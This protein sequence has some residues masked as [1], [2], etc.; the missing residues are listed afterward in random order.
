MN[1]YMVKLNPYGSITRFPDSQTL[2]GSICWAIRD[3]YGEDVLEDILENFYEHENRFVVSSVF[4]RGLI[5]I[6]MEVWTTVEETNNL[7][8]SIKGDKSKIIKRAKLLKKAKYMTL[9]VF[10]CYMKGSFNKKDMYQSILLG[11]GKGKYKLIENILAFSDEKVSK[12]SYKVDKGKRNKINRKSGSTE[13][14][15]LYY[16]NRTF[17]DKNAELYFFIKTNNIEFFEPIFRYLSDS[18]IGSDK[19]IG[20]NSYK[21]ELGN[22]FT[23]EKNIYESI[24]FS[25][26][27]PY[28]DEIDWDNSYFKI[29]FGSYKVES[30]FKFM[31][32]DIFK[33]EVGY[34]TEGSKIMLKANKEIYGQLPIVK[35]LNG[36]KIRHNGLGFFL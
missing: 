33:N 17:L 36:K 1:T 31:G 24:L 34:L 7:L 15:N 19:S 28:Y 9:E 32:Q 22:K 13:E 5:S 30:R 21:V 35:I 18:G 29:E 12:V 6:P 10:R 2:F 4:P 20:A 16:Y 23:Y 25:K 3:M 14:G 26:Y 27:I 11:D 8:D